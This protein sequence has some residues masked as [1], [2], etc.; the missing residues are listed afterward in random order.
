MKCG[1]LMIRTAVLWG[2]AAAAAAAVGY[3]VPSIPSL[4]IG[5]GLS[6][7]VRRCIPGLTGQGRSDHVSLTFD[8]G[9]DGA[10]TPEILDI[11]GELDVA[12]TFFV[13]GKQ[14]VSHP[15]VVQRQVS[16]GHEIGLHGWHHR[17]SLLVSPH[18]LKTSLTRA[19]AQIA[20]TAGVRPRFYRPPYGM[21]SAAT[22]WA[23]RKLGL[24]PVLWD[25]SAN[26]WR[27]GVTPDEVV[28]DVLRNARGG[29]TVLLHDSDCMA[30][31]GSW[32]VTAAALRR[33]VLALQG[34]GLTVGPLRDHIAA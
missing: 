14:V 6:P 16:E 21:S 34:E 30:T 8:D 3:A 32:R 9:P 18:E 7:A 12:A 11:L 10:G 15:G 5:A 2:G 27:A 1:G 33:I 28:R 4:A 17:N 24:T 29:S 26:D 23:G 22:L 19:V 25:A 13:L 20:D 31:P